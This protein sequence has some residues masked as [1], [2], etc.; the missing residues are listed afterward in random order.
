MTDVGAKIGP[1]GDPNV[2]RSLQSSEVKPGD[3][4]VAASV[5]RSNSTVFTHDKQFTPK[6]PSANI[7]THTPKH[8]P[9]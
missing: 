1:A 7:P 5:V 6:L 3:S 2:V 9:Q 8:P 4:K